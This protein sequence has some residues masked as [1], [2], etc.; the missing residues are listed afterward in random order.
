MA[1]ASKANPQGGEKLGYLGL[2]LMG[3]PMSRRLLAAGYQVTVW[4][5]SH[6]KVAPLV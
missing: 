3:A 1:D 6:G 5:R 4:N 2:G